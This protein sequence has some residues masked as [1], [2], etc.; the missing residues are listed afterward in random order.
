MNKFFRSGFPAAANL[1]RLVPLHKKGDPADPA[2]YRGITII[3][4]W[5]KL[6]ASLWNRRLS[7]AL[8]TANLRA[9]GQSGFRPGRRTS[10]NLFLLHHHI[11]RARASKKRLYACFVDLSGPG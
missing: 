8:E 10:D 11:Q 6:Y 5:A 7:S 4:L 2:N 3:S 1:A 9:I